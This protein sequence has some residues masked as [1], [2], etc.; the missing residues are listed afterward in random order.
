M[1]HFHRKPICQVHLLVFSL[2]VT[3]SITITLS[4]RFVLSPYYITLK[5][6][7]RIK[8][9]NPVKIWTWFS[10]SLMHLNEQQAPP[11]EILQQH[12]C[13]FLSQKY[14]PLNQNDPSGLSCCHYVSKH[15][16]YHYSMCLLKGLYLH[17]SRWRSLAWTKF[18]S[19]QTLLMLITVFLLMKSRTS[20]FVHQFFGGQAQRSY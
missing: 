4:R 15:G 14:T 1:S 20:A 5:S 19:I 18:I 3:I 16:N 13:S 7:S 10:R 12:A 17:I 8:E 2:S 6:S 9:I 11:F